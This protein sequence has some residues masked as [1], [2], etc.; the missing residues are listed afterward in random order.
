MICSAC[1]FE[2]PVEMKFCGR[3]G[4]SVMWRHA[5]RPNH[6]SLCAG[7]LDPPTGLHTNQVIYTSA[8]SD[9]HDLDSAVPSWPL[10]RE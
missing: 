8:A 4:A 3:C 5:D 1:G 6:V 2:N 7:L 9:Y 10:E